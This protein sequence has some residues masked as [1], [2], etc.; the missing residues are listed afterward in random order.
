[1]KQDI[2]QVKLKGPQ[3]KP[4]ANNLNLIPRPQ[5]G[6]P[7]KGGGVGRTQQNFYNPAV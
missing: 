4:A 3:V 6:A 7:G 5:T 1:M 2:S